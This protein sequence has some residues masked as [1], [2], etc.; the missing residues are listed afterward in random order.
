MAAAIRCY[1]CKDFATIIWWS[2]ANG[3]TG[4]CCDTCYPKAVMA[5]GGS[6]GSFVLDGLKLSERS[7]CWPEH[8]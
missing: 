5:K 3:Y 8:Y 7:I 6:E 2:R 1:W 4:P